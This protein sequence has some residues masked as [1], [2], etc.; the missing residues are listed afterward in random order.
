VNSIQGPGN[1][2]YDSQ[3]L[4]VSRR[5]TAESVKPNVFKDDESKQVQLNI[6]DQVA[7][8]AEAKELLKQLKKEGKK[9]ASSKDEDFESLL[10][11]LRKL[12]EEAEKRGI[13]QLWLIASA[14]GRSVY[15]R[16]GF[17]E[18]EDYLK[19]RL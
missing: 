5:L 16:S 14:Q 19:L 11:N 15:E 9:I 2:R 8:S 18:A 17:T 12:K 1:V 13:R 7:L 6:K 10:G 4:K 3:H